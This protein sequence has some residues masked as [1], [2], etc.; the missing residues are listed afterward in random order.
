MLSSEERRL[1]IGILALLLFGAM[2]DAC[3]S[4]VVTQETERTVLPG[5][6]PVKP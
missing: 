1:I 4:R 6:K 5:V 3:R 2:V